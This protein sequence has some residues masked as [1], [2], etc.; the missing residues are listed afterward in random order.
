MIFY[1]KK[2]WINL[3]KKSE[4]V[5]FGIM[6]FKHVNLNVNVHIKWYHF[7][8]FLIFNEI[9]NFKQRPLILMIKLFFYA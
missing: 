2:F 7:F 6:I 4:H 1:I 3:K 9:I 5:L 8:S